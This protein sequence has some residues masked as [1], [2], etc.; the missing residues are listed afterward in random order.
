M[1]AVGWVLGCRLGKEKGVPKEKR[2]G[3]KL[4]GQPYRQGDG[5][6]SSSLL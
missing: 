2:S 6:T 4:R 3:M 1:A 5:D